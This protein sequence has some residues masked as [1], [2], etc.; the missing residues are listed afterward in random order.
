MNLRSRIVLDSKTVPGVRIHFRLFGVRRRA[1]VNLAI[2]EHYDKLRPVA[3]QLQEC[4]I[5]P[6]E[7]N[8]KGEVV[9]KGDPPEVVLQKLK[10]QTIVRRHYEAVEAAYI[11]EPTLLAYVEKVEGLTLNGEPI[12]TADSFVENA[13]DELAD[14]AYHFVTAHNGLTAGESSASGQLGTSTS[15]EATTTPSTTATTAANPA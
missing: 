5:V 13:P 9:R 15:P 3:E 12:T 6:E 11:L 14:E 4:A 2:A 1:A 8:E 10:K 7:T